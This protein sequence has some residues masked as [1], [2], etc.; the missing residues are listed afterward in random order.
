[1]FQNASTRLIMRL[2]ITVSHLISML[3]FCEQIKIVTILNYDSWMNHKTTH[4]QRE[5]SCRLTVAHWTGKNK[6]WIFALNSQ[7]WF[8]QQNSESGTAPLPWLSLSRVASARSQ[9][10][11]L[12]FHWGNTFCC[13][14][15]KLVHED[16][17]Q[18]N[19]SYCP[20]FL[21]DLKWNKIH[22]DSI[23]PYRK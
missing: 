5:Y 14:V 2:Q 7:I 6:T 16:L 8:D 4:G 19:C 11:F 15:V 21:L 22:K 17:L 23:W 10:T 9:D 13:I 12:G 3:W 1:M 20:E 18:G